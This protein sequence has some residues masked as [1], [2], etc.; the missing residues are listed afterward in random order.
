MDEK[1]ARDGKIQ[2]KYTEEHP[3]REL[4]VKQPQN[5]IAV[6]VC[7]CCANRYR[8]QFVGL[9][10]VIDGVEE[11]GRQDG[12]VLFLIEIDTPTQRRWVSSMGALHFN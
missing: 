7:G 10:L 11:Q 6:Y 3:A 9:K 5:T 12:R 8:C 1:G 2:R 4:R